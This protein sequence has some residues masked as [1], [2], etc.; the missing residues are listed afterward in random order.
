MNNATHRGCVHIC[1]SLYTNDYNLFLPQ[2][3]R[4]TFALISLD[5]LKDEYAVRRG[6]EEDRMCGGRQVY[7]AE[8]SVLDATHEAATNGQI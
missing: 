7:Q 8:P 5:L 3:L 4:S 1:T 6:E 2:D